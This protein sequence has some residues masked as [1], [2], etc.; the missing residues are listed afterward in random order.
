[1]AC[2]RGPGAGDE[3]KPKSACPQRLKQIVV[4]KPQT[5]TCPSGLSWPQAS[6]AY[7]HWSPMERGRGIGI[8]R[9]PIS[10]SVADMIVSGIQC[11]LG[12]LVSIVHNSLPWGSCQLIPTYWREKTFSTKACGP[13]PDWTDRSLCHCCGM[14]GQRN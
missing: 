6:I 14:G 10:S 11:W 7:L 2:L 8:A 3:T 4:Y 9:T 5:G 1:M 12:L 13:V